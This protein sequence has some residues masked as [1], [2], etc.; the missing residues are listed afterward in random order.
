MTSRLVLAIALCAGAV[1]ISGQEDAPVSALS[2]AQRQALQQIIQSADK[3]TKVQ[4]EA[5]SQRLGEIA[6]RID[7][8][9]LSDKPDD[10]LHH[11]LC[12]ELTDAIGGLVRTAISAKLKVAGDLVKVLTPDQKRLVLA[13]LD[14][15][16]ANP[17]LTELIGKVFAETKK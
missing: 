3:E 5:D 2:P 8:N 17:D 10:E 14:R 7:R 11:K 16:G 9:L 15:P 4:A 12:A 1:A 13:E 6:Q